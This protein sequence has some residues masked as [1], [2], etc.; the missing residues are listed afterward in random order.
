MARD[1]QPIAMKEALD[2]YE[3]LGDLLEALDGAEPAH[4]STNNKMA[5]RYTSARTGE[6]LYAQHLCDK[7]KVLIT[8]QYHAFRGTDLSMVG[9][10]ED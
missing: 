3:Q 7:L 9:A 2:V 4:A 6:L 1:K 8:D 5:A 10:P